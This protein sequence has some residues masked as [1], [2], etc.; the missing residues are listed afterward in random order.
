MGIT[1]E[2]EILIEANSLFREPFGSEAQDPDSKE[3][4]AE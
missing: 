1:E 4:G 2:S 3:T